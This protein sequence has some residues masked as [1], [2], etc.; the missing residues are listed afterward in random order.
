MKL[1]QDA[2]PTNLDE[3]VN[4]L[5]ESLTQRDHQEIKELLKTDSALSSTHHFLGTYLRNN[6]SLWEDCP[7]VRWF[8]KEYKIVHADDI[9][10]IILEAFSHRYRGLNYDPVST[11]KR[12]HKHWEQYYGENAADKMIAEWEL[13]NNDR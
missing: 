1:N 3:A 9:S 8:I 10:G 11:V 2:V 5:I 7:L 12:F 13:S 4:F 6:W